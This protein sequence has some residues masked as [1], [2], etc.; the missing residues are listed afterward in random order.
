MTLCWVHRG[1]VSRVSA[2]FTVGVM[3]RRVAGGLG[4]A[5][6]SGAGHVSGASAPRP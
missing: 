5:L 2:E 6:G 3:H 1:D 4:P